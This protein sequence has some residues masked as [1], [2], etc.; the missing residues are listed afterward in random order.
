MHVFIDIYVSILKDSKNLK[1]DLNL[2][3]SK[4]LVSSKLISLL[5]IGL[6]KFEMFTMESAKK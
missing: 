1:M 3:E 2:V 5:K 4:S 6:S